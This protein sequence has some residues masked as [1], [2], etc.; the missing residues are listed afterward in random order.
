MVKFISNYALRAGLWLPDA[1][2]W[3]LAML[4]AGGGVPTAGL[5]FWVKIAQN[6][7]HQ[8]LETLEAD[9]RRIFPKCKNPASNN[10]NP[11]ASIRHPEPDDYFP[12]Y[13]CKIT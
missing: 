12:V 5:A 13:R 4:D 2:Y 3:I 11:T 7:S 1:R 8:S 9:T 6:G 10:Q